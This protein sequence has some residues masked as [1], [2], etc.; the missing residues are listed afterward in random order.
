MKTAFIFLLIVLSSCTIL[1]DKSLQ[2][3]NSEFTYKYTEEYTGL[4]THIFING[5][6]QCDQVKESLVLPYYYSIMFYADDLVCSTSDDA[7]KVFGDVN[8]PA[9]TWGTY[10][11]C[12]DTIKCQ[13]ISKDYVRTKIVV[14]TS[15]FLIRGMDKL[16]KIEGSNVGVTYTFHPF[17]NRSGYENWLLKKKWFY[18]KGKK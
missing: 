5:Y 13:F 16:E 4:D 6:Y 1:V 14:T 3:S 15:S 12:G 2:P 18:K 8:S 9:K 10:R 17:A 11:L 7:V